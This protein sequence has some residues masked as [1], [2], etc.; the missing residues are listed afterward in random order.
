MGQNK[1]NY[2]KYCSKPALSTLNTLSPYI[3]NK[4]LPTSFARVRTTLSDLPVLPSSKRSL[5]FALSACLLLPLTSCAGSSLQGAFQPDERLKDN[6]VLFGATRSSPSPQATTQPTLPDDFPDA[7]PIYPNATLASTGSANNTVASREG[8]SAP[9]T[10]YRWLTPDPSNKVLSFYN[11]QFQ[12]NGWQVLSQPNDD[13]QGTFEAK[14]DDLQ[15]MVTVQPAV[16]AAQPTNDSNRSTEIEI[17]YVQGGNATVAQAGNGATA[18]KPGDPNFIGPVLPD[19]DTTTVTTN[20]TAGATPTPEPN[21]FADL[22]K[23]PKELRSY[24]TDVAQLGVLSLA[25][26]Q[27]KGNATSSTQ[28]DPNKVITRREYARWLV[29]ATNRFYADQPAKQIRLGVGTEQ[30]AFQDV[31]RSDPDFPV[32][33]GLADAGLIPSSLSGDSTT[34]SFRPD[35][36]LT[37]ENLVLWKVPIDTRQALPTASIDAI[38]Q[39]WGFQDVAKIDPRAQRAVLADFQ[40]GDLSNIRRVLGYTTLFQPKKPVT[41][42]EA[43]AALWYF[44]AQGEGLSAKDVLKSAQTNSQTDTNQ[45]TENQPPPTD[46]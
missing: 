36:P 21:T 35:A 5:Q 7:I 12:T 25:S 9:T 33:Q 29:A 11:Q 18:P 44:G 17:R 2:R 20:P 22:N 15:V 26:T 43:A 3:N 32:I 16:F 27:G 28:L 1:A 13:L 45:T 4:Q 42:A 41:R 34:V 38:K 30:P 37:R 46:G 24:V 39:T 10:A 31:P 19:G 14:K 6:P 40:N 8:N 23:V